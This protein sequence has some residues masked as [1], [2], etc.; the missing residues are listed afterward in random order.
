MI[1]LVSHPIEPHPLS[2]LP[3]A[4]MLLCIALLP[5]ILK[6]HWERN[7]HRIAITLAALTTAY[8]TFSLRYPQRL[9][10][11]AADYVRFMA[12][13]GSLF[14]IAGGIHIEMRGEARPLR[15]CVFLALGG[16]L[17]NALGTTGASM[18][19]IRPW[20]RLNKFRYTGLHTAFFIFLVSNF[21]GG[22]LPMGPPLFLGYL[23]GVPFFWVLTKCWRPWTMSMF[24]LLVIFY[25]VDR[26]NYRRAPRETRRALTE[27]SGIKIGGLRN[28]IFLA[29]VLAAVFI[30][31]PLFLREALMVMAATAAYFATPKRLHEAND[32]S[33]G[34]L[35]EVG[36]L[37]L[38]IFFTMVPVL[39]FMR[40]HAAELPIDSPMEFYWV[41]GGLSSVLDNAPTYLTFLADAMGRQ[42]LSVENAVDVQGFLNSG[43]AELAAISMGAVFF[44]AAT[45]IGNSPN[46]MVKA[47]VD[48]HGVHAPTFFGFIFKF[49]VPILLPVL[50]IVSFSVSRH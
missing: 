2:M 8:Y 29:V 37:F 47:I 26:H 46:F 22:L 12:L 17:G 14:V 6:H 41:S 1:A 24:L 48:R 44:G 31:R 20:I 39:D 5:S 27:T 19:L 15:N 10:H 36:W 16:I 4:A 38:G 32:F 34:P 40:F 25:F 3:F 18:L 13:V 23:K 49:A 21:G 7:Y 33:F 45:Y 28:L 30:Q 11:E 35:K 42:N 9:V 43:A 50:W